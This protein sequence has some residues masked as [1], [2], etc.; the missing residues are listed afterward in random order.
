VDQ[1]SA[2]PAPSFLPG[3]DAAWEQ[4]WE[5]V[6]SLL[7]RL[8]RAARLGRSRVITTAAEA[9]DPTDKEDRGNDPQDGVDEPEA[10]KDQCQKQDNQN[11]SHIFPS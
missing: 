10:S 4:L 8:P 7:R 9:K 2:L 6:S 11:Q 1:L 3:A 5:P